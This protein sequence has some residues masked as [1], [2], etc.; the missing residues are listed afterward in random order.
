L[1]HGLK[2][3]ILYDHRGAD[4]A[5]FVMHYP[6]RFCLLM[7]LS[8]VEAPLIR[9]YTSRRKAIILVYNKRATFEI[10]EKR[11]LDEGLAYC[12]EDTFPHSPQRT[13]KAMH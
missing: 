5:R 11:I 9:L 8:L 1:L 12:E 10:P 7:S 13:T 3:S 2:K 6:N 4:G